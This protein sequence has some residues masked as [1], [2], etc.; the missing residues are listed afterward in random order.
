MLLA[1]RSPPTHHFLSCTGR[2]VSHGDHRAP[3]SDHG[4]PSGSLLRHRHGAP[5]PALSLAADRSPQGTKLQ[6]KEDTP[7]QQQS[8]TL[9]RNL[10][11]TSI[12]SIAYLRG[13]FPEGA[14]PQ[15]VTPYHL[16]TLHRLLQR[17]Q[18][19]RSSLLRA[20]A[21]DLTIVGIGIKSLVPLSPNS[22]LL[23]K[24]LEDG[25]YVLLELPTTAHLLRFDALEKKYV[26]FSALFT[27]DTH[28]GSFA[29][30]FLASV[31]RRPTFRSPT[32]VRAPQFLLHCRTLTHR[33]PHHI[34]GRRPWRASVAHGELG[35][36]DRH[37]AREL[38]G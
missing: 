27:A 4:V 18:P 36:P 13:L 30:S 34:F 6:L 26:R 8:L 3:R 11:R 2:A 24:W 29:N 14:T 5:L 31:H 1:L 21:S 38:Q 22:T 19:G 16:H 9:M 32:T 20:T 35:A 28:L 23:V 15:R 12:S 25:V 33:S 10:L 37:H 17:S 7:T